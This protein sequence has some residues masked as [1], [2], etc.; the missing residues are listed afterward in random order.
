MTGD[1]RKETEAKLQQL[2]PAVGKALGRW[3][4]VDR[5]MGHLVELAH[6]TEKGQAVYLSATYPEAN[7]GRIVARGVLPSR[8]KHDESV[9]THGVES[10]RI[11][12]ASDRGAEAIAGEVKRR[13]LPAY[14]VA[15]AEMRKRIEEAEA[16]RDQRTELAAR[17][18]ALCGAEGA[19]KDGRF[20]LPDDCAMY[21][22]VAAQ[23]DRVRIEA[24]FSPAQAEAVLRA[25]A[26][27]HKGSK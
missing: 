27:L 21:G 3:R 24:S 15:L 18:V 25:L 11:T 20:S 16:D 10:P 4:V 5:E 13:L 17:L 1:A 22:T 19:D 23:C 7:H 6:P 2:G 14:L 12:I 9:S 26:A 8:T